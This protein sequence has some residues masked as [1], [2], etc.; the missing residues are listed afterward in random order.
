MKLITF[1]LFLTVGTLA[2]CQSQD[3]EPN[4]D[5]IYPVPQ[6]Q[7]IAWSQMQ[8]PE[9]AQQDPQKP[10]VPDPKPDTQPEPQQKP[11]AP[12][13]QNHSQQP[14]QSSQMTLTGMVVKVK[15][16]FVLKAADGTYQLDNQAKAQPYEG[17]QVKVVGNLDASTKTLHVQSIELVS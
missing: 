4:P 16:Q 12:E 10:T 6:S 13:A 5:S 15:N 3:I 2:F 8:Q 7:L 11:S 1:L 14:D 9:P 17:K